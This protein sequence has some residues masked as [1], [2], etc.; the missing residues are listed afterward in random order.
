MKITC[1]WLTL[2]AEETATFTS[3][4]YDMIMSS[5]ALIASKFSLDTDSE[6]VDRIIEETR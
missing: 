1:A 2:I 6:I 5:K 3:N 4:D